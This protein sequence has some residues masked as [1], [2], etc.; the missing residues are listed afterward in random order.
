M[1]GAKLGTGGKGI[2]G[3]ASPKKK[4]PAKPANPKAALVINVE[5]DADYSKNEFWLSK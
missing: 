2:G 3:P 1:V 4:R 5:I